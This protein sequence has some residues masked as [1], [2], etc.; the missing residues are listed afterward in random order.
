MDR[1]TRPITVPI[2]AAVLFLAA[3]IALLVGYSLLFPNP[4]MDRL[5]ELNQ[6]VDE[7]FR[8][9]AKPM[10]VVLFAIGVATACAAGGLLRGKRWAWWFAVALFAMDACGDAIRVFITGEIWRS[11]AGVLISGAFLYFLVRSPVRRY[12]SAGTRR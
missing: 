7:A 4:L 6:P 11:A 12:F 1:I 9:I 2:V 3:G 5:W 8:P 10:S